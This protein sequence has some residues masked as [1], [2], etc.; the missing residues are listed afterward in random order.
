M[1][2][3]GSV[4][5]SFSRTA[6]QTLSRSHCRNIKQKISQWEGRTKGI[7]QEERQELKDFG[8][9]YGLNSK[10]K[11]S[12]PAPHRSIEG[13]ANVQR[14]G[15]DFW[16]NSNLGSVTEEEEEEE[17]RRFQEVSRNRLVE[18]LSSD[19]LSETADATEWPRERLPPGNFYTSRDLW[20]QIKTLPFD[21]E[22]SIALDLKRKRE[23]CGSTEKELNVA[24]AKSQETIYCDV[25]S[26]ERQPVINPVPKPQRTF[27]YHSEKDQGNFANEYHGNKKPLEQLCNG[28]YPATAFYES[29]HRTGSR[30]IRSRSKRWV[31]A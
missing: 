8:V 31:A 20:K 4:D 17:D 12:A 11:P 10:E 18:Q 7:C 15:L 22:A 19:T 29:D 27:R 24:P 25:E 23:S 26:Q 3:T 16:E 6:V 1:H 30:G 2:P 13:L 5:T 14:L 9:R 28:S 21:Q